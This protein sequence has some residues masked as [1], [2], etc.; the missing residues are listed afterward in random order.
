MFFRLGSLLSVL[1]VCFSLLVGCGGG[2]D[3]AIV[4]Q[5]SP[6]EVLTDG[7]GSV[8]GYVYAFNSRDF[9]SDSMVL[10]DGEISSGIQGYSPVSGVQINL[11]A[12]PRISG[13][14]DGNGFFTLENVPYSQIGDLTV[15]EAS[16]SEFSPIIFFSMSN[17][18]SS[19]TD[20]TRLYIL[21]SI[22]TVLTGRI[23]QFKCFG[24]DSSNRLI[25]P[26]S[27]E[28]QLEGDIGDIYSN[29][30]FVAT[31]VGQG[32]IIASVGGVKE[33]IEIEVISDDAVGDLAGTVTYSDGTPAEGLFVTADVIS[34]ASETDASGSYSLIN[35][36]SGERGIK[37]IS[38]GVIIWE[39]NTVINQGQENIFDIILDMEA[40]PP[41]ITSLVPS[42][43]AL[44]ADV[45]ITGYNFGSSQGEGFVSL[46]GQPVDIQVWTNNLITF[47]V[48][49]DA[50][51]G[52]VL[53]N[54]GEE[55]NSVNLIVTEAEPETDS[56]YKAEL[57]YQSPDIIIE[58]YDLVELRVDFKN[59]GSIDWD[60]DVVFLG[61]SHP[62]NR[63]TNLFVSDS[64]F[65]QYRIKMEQ[66]EPVPPGGT[67]E[68]IFQIYPTEEYGYGAFQDFELRADIAYQDVEP[69]WFGVDGSVEI[70]VVVVD[71]FYYE[72][73][74]VS[75][76][77]SIALEPGV[78]QTVTVTYKNV[79]TMP[80]SP[81]AVHLGTTNSQ[82]RMCPL[83]MVDPSWISP[84]RIFMGE[85]D[86]VQQGETF[87]FTFPVILKIPED[88]GYVSGTIE[89][90]RMVADSEYLG[91]PGQWFGESSIV[92]ITV[93]VNP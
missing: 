82:D 45:T 42:T 58:R 49:S 51:T 91:H 34:W 35:V 1:I 76:P 38:N 10:L 24:E 68:F 87:D 4:N 89:S 39:N 50:S 33:E 84:N 93:N 44:G 66:T 90:F 19:S 53:V 46:N 61:T 28:W 25:N 31:S 55:S 52:A 7:T 71:Q 30:V 88:D 47:T 9:S 14:T 18:K 37:V 59:V 74:L 72:A 81:D 17:V 16:H 86:A 3:T 69:Q 56:P 21:P 64:W 27:V 77:G 32:K 78:Q 54:T 60:P 85:V 22:A 63:I 67:A 5:A 2:S 83:Y 11:M 15:L 23:I 65:S 75:S 29:G 20:I 36:P 92:D 79:G 48:P 6:Q 40:P 13:I 70:N 57:V 12:D 73:E 62:Y 8:S 41:V 26:E 80:W 43:A